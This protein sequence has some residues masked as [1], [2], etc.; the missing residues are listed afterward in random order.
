MYK[1]LAIDDSA[2]IREL[3]QS[4]LEDDDYEVATADGGTQGIELAQSFKPDLII[5]DVEMP[6]MDGFGVLE[7]IRQHE[8]LQHIPFIYLTGLN[9]M[10]HL[11]QGMNL[12]ADDYLTKPFLPAELLRVVDLRLQ[13]Q[14]NLTAQFENKIQQAEQKVEQVLNYDEVTGLPNKAQL[15]QS[16][17]EFQQ[18][19]SEF[20]VFVVA[21][22]Q[23][24]QLRQEHPESLLNIVLKGL[25]NRIQQFLNSA[26]PASKLFYVAG[27]Q[28]VA[29]VP[30]GSSPPM[31]QS[32]LLLEKLA[33]PVTIMGRQLHLSAS[34]GLS[35]HPQNSSLLN[36]L[37]QQASQARSKAELNG[38]NQSQFYH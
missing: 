10:K 13:K 9:D 2:N 29:L 37:V 11:R 19:H 22:D 38:G 28:F 15:A 5:C 6:D 34:A 20:S 4:F 24:E 31:Y 35:Q 21:L 30:K 36:E 18:Q 1:V 7:K 16:F 14:K 12:G 27:N 23:F 25:A 33:E 17:F 3:I 26:S 8:D 32:Q